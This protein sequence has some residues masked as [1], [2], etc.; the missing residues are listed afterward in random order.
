MMATP[1]ELTELAELISLVYG[2]HGEA[3]VTEEFT[4]ALKHPRDSLEALRWVAGVE[5][6]LRTLQ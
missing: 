1:D 2:D 5:L 4:S 3:A 6:R